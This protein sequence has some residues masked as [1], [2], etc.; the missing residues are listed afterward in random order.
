LIISGGLFTFAGVGFVPVALTIFGAWVVTAMSAQITGQTGINPMEIFAI[1]VLLSVNVVYKL[2]VTE[3]FYVAAAVAVVCGLTGDVM[4]DFKSG[5]ILKTDP[6]A[7]M[8]AELVGGT[9]G[10][11]VSVLVFMAMR[12]AFGAMGPGTD[13]PAP[14][15][16]AVSA[17]VGGLPNPKAFFIG[18]TFG[19]LLYVIGKP[20]MTFGLG[21]YLP[22]FISVTVFA[23]GIVAFAAK[24]ILSAYQKT[25]EKMKKRVS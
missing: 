4:N 3:A 20:A 18:L 14:Q 24:K 23:G 17:M 5:H 19:T 16:Y 22:M 7:Q 6:R 15:A 12:A 1:T 2:G 21:V 10:A 8:I 25:H 9:V 13:M 11:V